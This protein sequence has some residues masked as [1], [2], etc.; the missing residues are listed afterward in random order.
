MAHMVE[1][2]AYNKVQKPWH[3]LGNPVNAGMSVEEMLQAAGLDWDNTSQELYVMRNGI[4]VPL[5][6][7]NADNTKYRAII[8]ESDGYIHNIMTADYN[9]VQNRVVMAFLREFVEKSGMTLETAGALRH[10]SLIWVLAK[11]EASFTLPG[12]DFNQT[13][14]LLTNSHD[15]SQEFNGQFTSVRVVCAN[16]VRLAQSSKRGRSFSLKHSAKL[17][18]KAISAAKVEMGLAIEATEKYAELAERMVATKVS[19][20]DTLAYVRALVPDKEDKKSLLS[21]VVEN[22]ENILTRIVEEQSTVS[23]FSRKGKDLLLAIQNGPG[24]DLESSRDTV[25]GL[26]NGATYYVDHV[27]G[28]ER[29]TALNSAWFGQGAK[30]KETAHNLAVA[31]VNR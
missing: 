17:D 24:S 4:A 16:T 31:L 18:D 28:R 11:I 23:D 26:L 14:V 22:S 13:Y 7:L 6:G 30:L 3:G 10:G 1:T 29:D 19:N 15:G 21:S 12:N 27:A 25:W 2:M 8:R 9:I 5:D 20:D